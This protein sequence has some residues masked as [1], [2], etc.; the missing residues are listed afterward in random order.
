MS[1][2]RKDNDMDFSRR[3][4]NTRARLDVVA[5]VFVFKNGDQYTAICSGKKLV[6]MQATCESWDE[7][8]K[9]AASRCV[10]P[11]RARKRTKSTGKLKPSTE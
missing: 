7:A 5:F 8:V 9:V 3:D 10:G 4:F 1:R 2:S 6:P 11:R